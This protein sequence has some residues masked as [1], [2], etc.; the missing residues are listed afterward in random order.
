M[1]KFIILIGVALFASG[2]GAIKQFDY[3][4]ITNEDIEIVLKEWAKRDLSAQSIEV[5]V[6]EEDSG[7]LLVKHKLNNAIHYGAI[8]LPQGEDLSNA[9]VMIV[10]DGLNQEKPSMD[11]NSHPKSGYA[12]L[13]PYTKFIKI[14]PS[15]RGRTAFYKGIGY[16]SEGDFCDAYDGATDDAIS[17]INVAE[18]LFPEANYENI[19]A[20]GYSRGGLVALLLG[21]R[22]TRIHTV[23]AFAAPTDFYRKSVSENYGAQYQCQFIEGKTNI[24]SRTRMLASSPVYF[25]PQENLQI[26]DIHHGAI[27]EVVPV[28]NASA[29]SDHLRLFDVDLNVSI[30]PEGEH[31]IYTDSSATFEKSRSGLYMFIRDLGI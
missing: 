13:D 6:N 15:F 16:H 27:D 4:P 26:V 11:L 2:C 5:L 30:Y 12:R 18:A 28:W 20:T 8:L 7:F 21:V 19:F 10:L 9:P 25:S 23:S 29:M 14:F 31:D 22:D 17:L 3:R 24:E 1:N